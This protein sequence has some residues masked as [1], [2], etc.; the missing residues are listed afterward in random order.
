[1]QSQL[2]EVHVAPQGK[3]LVWVDESSIAPLQLVTIVPPETASS[4]LPKPPCTS[5]GAS[6]NALPAQQQQQQQ[7]QQAIPGSQTGRHGAATAQSLRSYR[8]QRAPCPMDQL[9]SWSAALLMALSGW[10]GS[11]LPC[12]IS[13]GT[14]LCP[15][16]P[17]VYGFAPLVEEA[18]PKRP[19]PSHQPA[20]NVSNT[21]M[22]K[23]GALLWC[24]LPTG[25]LY[26]CPSSHTSVSWGWTLPS[27][28]RTPYICSGAP[29]GFWLPAGTS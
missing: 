28:K 9:A 6:T 29:L 4:E 7:Q 1:M 5:P 13:P 23:G 25:S 26:G 17:F 16:W 11:V 12:R 19:A 20:T 2:C 22:T 15:G 10:T 27:C 3:S 21:S 24:L 18:G 8:T 14:H